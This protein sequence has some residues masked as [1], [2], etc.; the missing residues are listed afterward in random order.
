MREPRHLD[1]IVGQ[2]I[3]D[4]VRGCL[5]LDRGVHCQDHFAHATLGD[6]P[7]QARQIEIGRTNAVERR[8]GAP[9]HMVARPGGAR[10]LQSPKI[11]DGLHD[12]E[13]RRVAPLIRTDRAGIARVDI[14][15]DR[16]GQDALLRDAQRLGERRKQRL[17]LTDEVERDAARRTRPQSRQAREKLDE[18]L[19]FRSGDVGRH[20]ASRMAA[21]CRAEGVALPSAPASSPPPCGPP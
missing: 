20:P 1:G 8:K 6:A 15:A 7:D 3:D 16:T 13:R 21:S 10:P 12:D 18:A 14:A 11:A 17:A 5:A 19:D 2:E 9:K 4:V